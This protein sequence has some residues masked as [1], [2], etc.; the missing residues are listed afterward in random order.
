[1]QEE[2][3]QTVM[4]GLRAVV[5]KKGWFSAIYSDGASHFSEAKG[6]QSLDRRDVGL[7]PWRFLVFESTILK[8]T[9]MR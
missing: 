5:E 4:A 2:S 1:M 7:A 8:L 3:T 9:R 6:K